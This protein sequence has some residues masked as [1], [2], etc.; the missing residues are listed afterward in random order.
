MEQ[1]RLTVME[2]AMVGQDIGTKKLIIKVRGSVE[3]TAS[4][5][6]VIVLYNDNSS[7]ML[8]GLLKSYSLCIF[9]GLFVSKKS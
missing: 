7:S 3:R 8:G 9:I 6:Y 2:Q 1:V 5:S 4:F